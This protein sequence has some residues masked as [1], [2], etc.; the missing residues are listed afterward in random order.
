LKFESFAL[1]L[2]SFELGK[3]TRFEKKMVNEAAG[4]GFEPGNFRSV[5]GILKL[6]EFVHQIL[7]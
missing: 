2:N 1:D 5:N 4:I 6:I 3:N 7:F